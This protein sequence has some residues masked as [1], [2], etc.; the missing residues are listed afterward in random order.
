MIVILIIGL[1]S[2]F[3]SISAFYAAKD[4]SRILA[5]PYKICEPFGS[6]VWADHVIFGPF[7]ALV[8]FF[9]YFLNDWKLFLLIFSVFWLIRSSGET[10]YWFFQ[11]FHPRVGN[12]PSKFWINRYV[13]GEAVWFMHQIFWQCITVLSFILTILFGFIWIKELLG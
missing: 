1:I 4:K 12:E 6:F 7:W 2:I 11:Q 3:T 13:P 9:T 5:R 10:M 8:S